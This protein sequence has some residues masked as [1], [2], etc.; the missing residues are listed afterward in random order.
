MAFA[1]LNA[2]TLTSHLAFINRM[3]EAVGAAVVIK[4][5][6]LTSK[7]EWDNCFDANTQDHLIKG[8]FTSTKKSDAIRVYI[9]K[10]IAQYMKS[11]GVR[12]TAWTKVTIASENTTN[13]AISNRIAATEFQDNNELFKLVATRLMGFDDALVDFALAENNKEKAYWLAGYLAA[14]FDLV[15]TIAEISQKYP[16]A[17]GY[18]EQ[19]FDEGRMTPASFLSDFQ[20]LNEYIDGLDMS[21]SMV[22]ADVF[23]FMFELNERMS[24]KTTEAK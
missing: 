3:Q 24:R 14:Q 17:V 11:I 20:L 22:G 21:G 2:V 18:F 9:A 15:E 5:L 6:H 8:V 12:A 10:L 16:D 13:V 19:R 4:A 7:K 1:D 23:D